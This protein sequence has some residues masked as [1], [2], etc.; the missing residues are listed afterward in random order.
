MCIQYLRVLASH[1]LVLVR[2]P[3]ADI[4]YGTRHSHKRWDLG[5]LACFMCMSPSY[6]VQV[7][8][9][10]LQRKYHCVLQVLS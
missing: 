3:G 7:N 10:N 5:K 2:A 1:M 6:V 8:L 9:H 4:A